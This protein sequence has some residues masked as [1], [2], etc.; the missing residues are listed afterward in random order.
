MSSTDKYWPYLTSEGF[1]R[2]AF[3]LVQRDALRDF[4]DPLNERAQVQAAQARFFAAKRLQ[5]RD[6]KITR[7]T[8]MASAYLI[9]L[10]ALPYFLHLPEKVE[11]Y[12]NLVALITAVIVLVSSLLQYSRLDVVSAEQH[13]RCG[14]EI[15]ELLRKSAGPGRHDYYNITN[16]YNEILQKYSINHDDIDFWSV[17]IDRPEEYP[18]LTGWTKFYRTVAVLKD[19]YGPDFV[20]GGVTIL[21]VGFI[22][23][24]VL[25]NQSLQTSKEMQLS[26]NFG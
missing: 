22:L 9:G 4:E 7:L 3:H 10:T 12:V 14:L 18:W 23:F 24:Y 13:H 26:I 6:R 25:P 16:T 20:L 15:N 8:A 19:R 21:L 11:D 1:L 5:T 2:R 17:T